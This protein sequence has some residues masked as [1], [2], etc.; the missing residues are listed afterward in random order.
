MYIGENTLS[1]VMN[2]DTYIS[3]LYFPDINYIISYLLSYYYIFIVLT[4]LLGAQ[5]EVSR[6]LTIVLIYH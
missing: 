2:V 1:K 6:L 5:T 4:S 3:C